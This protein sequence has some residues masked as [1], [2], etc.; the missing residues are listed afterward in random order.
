M[1][2]NNDVTS[3]VTEPSRGTARSEWRARRD[4]LRNPPN[5]V[6]DEGIDLRRKVIPI[7]A[8]TENNVVPIRRPATWIND[9]IEQN[10]RLAQVKAEPCDP[11]PVGVYE[12]NEHLRRI[13]R[14][15]LPY[16][17]IDMPDRVEVRDII[18]AVAIHYDVRKADMLSARRTANVVRP[19]QVAMY[20][21]K[22]ITLRSLPDIGRR[23]GNRDHTTV[24]HAVRKIGALRQ[25][26][27]ELNAL[28]SKFES[29]LTPR[30]ENALVDTVLPP[31]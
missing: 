20:L 24:L 25:T 7:A 4:R 23:F 17:P 13:C 19:R 12:Y 9:L 5:A 26:D 1:L 8:V 31:T 6:K 30:D 21:A 2:E 11:V 3:G 15:G 28:L 22:Q 16:E 14:T 29:A 10:E 27:A 18:K